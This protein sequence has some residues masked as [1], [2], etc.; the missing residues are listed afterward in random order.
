MKSKIMIILSLVSTAVCFETPAFSV[1]QAA[2]AG[3]I[4]QTSGADIYRQRCAACHGPAGQGGPLA[5]RLVGVVGR[6]AAATNFNYSTA[7]KQAGLTWN[8]VSLDRFLSAPGRL[9]P[10]TRM[11][12]S[13][14]DKQQRVQ[15][16][17]YLANI[18]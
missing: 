5:P 12:V 11:A 10:G 9:V 16:I 13:V 17:T 4:S 15:L 2:I 1:N 3:P 6:R 14:P 8:K 18:H 7:L